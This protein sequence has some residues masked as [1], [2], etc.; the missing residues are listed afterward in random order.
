[1]YSRLPRFVLIACL[2]AT[3]SVACRDAPAPVP[4]PPPPPPLPAAADV[5]VTA[6]DD[7]Q[8]CA[9]DADCELA[10]YDCCGCNALGRQIGVR[11]DR[12]QALIARRSPICTTVSC[13]QG[14]SDDASCVALR[15]ICRDGRC[16]PDSA[17]APSPGVGVEKIPN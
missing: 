5:D 9:A 1:M 7:E 3:V 16:V 12:A 8:R 4:P 10:T 13:A 2:L 15:A 14:M 17:A 6:T 11:K